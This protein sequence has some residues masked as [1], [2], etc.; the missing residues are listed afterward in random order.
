MS[1]NYTQRGRQ[2]LTKRLLE[3]FEPTESGY[4]VMDSELRGF[5]VRVLPSGKRLYI[6]QYRVAGSRSA[7]NARRVTLGNYDHLT[8]DVARS[9][10]K[11]VLGRVAQGEDPAQDRA[12]WR[13]AP[14][15]ADLAPQ[16][17]ATVRR[18]R[19][20]NT[21]YEYERQMRRD[22]LPVLGRLRAREIERQHVAALKR[23][24]GGRYAANRLLAIA[25]AFF[26]WCEE[27]GYR[28]AGTNPCRG[29]KRHRE[30]SR[31]R[32]LSPEEASR[33]GAA[34]RSALD[35]GANPYAIAA[36]KLLLFS[37]MREGEALSLPWNA[38]DL[39]HGVV[40][41]PDA[42]TAERERTLTAP[43]LAILAE[44]PRQSNNPFVFPGAKR[45]SH[46]QDITRTWKRI[47][48]AAQLSDFRLHDLRHSF[49]SAAL[50]SGA[51][52]AII[53]ELLGHRSAQTTKRY[54]HLHSD[55]RRAAAEK[56]SSA[57]ASWLDGSRTR[58]LP[59]AR[60]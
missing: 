16:Y 48:N 38:V 7:L 6:T 11:D 21:H 49:A 26:G 35:G 51:S 30:E 34:M 9:M 3:R 29:I 59:L 23:N 44:L 39:E 17:L 55:V 10:A 25:S 52:L 27:H 53:G 42:K 37:G 19:K 43:A 32:Y 4:V 50:S 36:I 57:I 60:R 15:V 20:P 24:A 54:A 8:L 47:R 14:T 58:V 12:E 31:R 40:N 18:D 5:G 33:L 28:D 56:T 22:I 1:R 46:L 41:L 13:Q 2:K 45:G